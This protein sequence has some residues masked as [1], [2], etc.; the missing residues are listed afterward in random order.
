[1]RKAKSNLCPPAGNPPGSKVNQ[2][3]DP[4]PLL[5]NQHGVNGLQLFGE[6]TEQLWRLPGITAD[7]LRLDSSCWSAP[8]LVGTAAAQSIVS[9]FPQCW[10][11]WLCQLSYV[12][13]PHLQALARQLSCQTLL[14]A[15]Q[16]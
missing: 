11:Q 13:W 4:R 16:E 1:M 9:S 8:G 7:W 14:Y 2:P 15:T 6:H 5:R 3:T 10:T 12:E